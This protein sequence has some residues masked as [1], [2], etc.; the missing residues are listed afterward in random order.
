MSLT[1][2]R[3]V[4]PHVVVAPQPYSDKCLDCHCITMHTWCPGIIPRRIEPDGR[5]AIGEALKASRIRP[6]DLVEII[7]AADRTIIRTV[8]PPKVRGVVRSV[9]GR[10]KDRSDLVED[11]L[12]IREDDDDRPGTSLEADV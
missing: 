9:A 10:W 4:R 1:P 2:F 7:P 11:L 3:K 8:T 5:I 12:K 6:G